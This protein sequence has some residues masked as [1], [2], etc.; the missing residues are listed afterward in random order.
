MDGLNLGVL[1]SA[2]FLHPKGLIGIFDIG[3][4]S[5][6]VFSPNIEGGLIPALLI[7]TFLITEILPEPQMDAKAKD[8]AVAEALKAIEEQTPK[9]ETR[10]S[11][12]KPTKQH[13]KHPVTR[14][15]KASGLF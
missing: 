1:V 15:L 4:I 7:G 14:G 8:A 13:P 9:V 6:N 3:S 2:I 5:K 12:G 11:K 10:N